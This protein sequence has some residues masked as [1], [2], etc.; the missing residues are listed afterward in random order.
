MKTLK[1]TLAIFFVI[2]FC[3]SMAVSV[4]AA[5][6]QATAGIYGTLTCRSYQSGMGFYGNTT[7]TTN[8]DNAYLLVKY[9]FN[10]ESGT[11]INSTGT[12]QRSVTSYEYTRSFQHTTDDG[13]PTYV[14]YCG[15][16]RG[17]SQSPSAYVTKTIGYS[18][19]SSEFD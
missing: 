7:V 13:V 5:L 8:P 9:T 14:Q 1:K 10:L 3:I 4:S 2:A 15:E 11:Q 6:N 19:D 12:S 17:G 18:V 16:V